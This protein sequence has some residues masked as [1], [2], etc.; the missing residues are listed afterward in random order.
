MSPIWHGV[1]QVLGNA[2]EKRW[3]LRR[4][5]KIDPSKALN[6]MCFGKLFHMSN[7]NRCY[8]TVNYGRR[9]AMSE[10][11]QN[12]EEREALPTHSLARRAVGL[13]LEDPT[14]GEQDYGSRLAVGSCTLPQKR[15]RLV[16]AMTRHLNRSQPELIIIII[17]IITTTIFI[18]LPSWQSYC[19]N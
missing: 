3:H 10:H 14:S 2:S 9:S 18:V 17:I 16:C 4:D 1:S 5:R 7:G 11:Y 19:E 6:V 15:K 13:Q 8:E 12:V